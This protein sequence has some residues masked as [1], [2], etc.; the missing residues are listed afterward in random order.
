MLLSFAVG[1]FVMFLLHLK[2][3][4]PA[5]KSGSVK[6]TESKQQKKPEKKEGVEPT[7]DFYTLLPEM[8][9]MVDKKNKGSQPIVTS[10]S[11]DSDAAEVQSN[12]G[13]LA[14][15]GVSVSSASLETH[16]NYNIPKGMKVTHC[17]LYGND[18]A[19]VVKIYEA[20]INDGDAEEMGAGVINTEINCTDF[21]ATDT[22]YVVM[23]WSPTTA[24][25][26]LL[27]GGYITIAK[28]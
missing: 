26:D 3:N 17:M 28:I 5:D 6:T 13:T 25:S 19:N 14:V 23:K 8:E 27:Y 1:A 24:D 7:F 10:P 2:D 11:D 4:V 21:N 22:N 15:G 9:V 12:D 18:T 16:A 20:N